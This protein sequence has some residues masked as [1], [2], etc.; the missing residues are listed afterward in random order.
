M[1]SVDGRSTGGRESASTRAYRRL[2]DQILSCE[3][4]PGVSLNEGRLA[5]ALALSKTPV[6][7]ALAMLAHEGFV[8][9]LPR[10]GYRVT[11]LT[12]ADVQELFHLRLLLEPAATAL[13][14]ERA[15]ADQLHELR[16]LAEGPAGG[17]EPE[18]YETFVIRDREFHV[19][20]A[21]A[22]GNR[23]LAITLVAVL[24]SMQRLFLSG[25]DLRETADDQ[26]REHRELLAA[27][28]KGNHHLAH[29]IAVRQIES[30]RERVMG[31]LLAAMT[32]PGGTRRRA[33]VERPPRR[34]SAPAP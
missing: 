6:R 33:D 14:A 11:D 13:A 7:E 1:L 18:P 5:E 29:D 32:T 21:E 23:R 25:L 2:K 26:R 30:S 27:L 4:A 16:R 12:V 19:R 10:Q 8:E 31:A 20:L 28:L 9:V 15:T 24:E 22:S 34:R 3:L 17:R